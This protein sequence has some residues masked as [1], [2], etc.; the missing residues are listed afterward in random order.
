MDI[1]FFPNHEGILCVLNEAILTCTNII[2][3]L[4]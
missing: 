1:I 3:F 4:S 2:S